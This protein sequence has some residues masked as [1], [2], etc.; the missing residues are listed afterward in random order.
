MGY[1]CCEIYAPATTSEREDLHVTHS[2]CS[3]VEPTVRPTSGLVEGSVD[4][5]ESWRCYSVPLPLAPG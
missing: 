1:M 5:A 2:T 4:G 3:R